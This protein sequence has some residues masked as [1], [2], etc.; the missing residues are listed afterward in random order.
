[1]AANF[2]RFAARGINSSFRNKSGLC[3][4]EA[5]R[6][7][8]SCLVRHSRVLSSVQVMQPQ[9][10]SLVQ[11]ASRNFS[12]N[13]VPIICN[14]TAKIISNT[15]GTSEALEESSGECEDEATNGRKRIKP[16]EL[17]RDDP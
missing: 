10:T 4:R 11:I 17:Q 15:S 9:T 6:L 3:S 13:T 7:T 8:S 2:A 14:I 5:A 1:M 16:H 12:Q